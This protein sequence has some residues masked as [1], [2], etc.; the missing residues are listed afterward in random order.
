MAYGHPLNLSL[1]S[2]RQFIAFVKFQ[3]LMAYKKSMIYYNTVK[4]YDFGTIYA[5]L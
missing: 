4:M 5:M 1:K 2:K 3:A